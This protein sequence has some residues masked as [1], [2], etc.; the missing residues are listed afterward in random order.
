CS[1][2]CTYRTAWFKRRTAI[3][4]SFRRLP[5]LAALPTAE[6]AIPA[7]LGII[8]HQPGSGGNGDRQHDECEADLPWKHEQQDEA[9]DNPGNSPLGVRCHAD[10]ISSVPG[11]VPPGRPSCF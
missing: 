1:R 10:S 9:E 3:C 8:E 7:P 2:P 6:L 11:R 5:D 4:A